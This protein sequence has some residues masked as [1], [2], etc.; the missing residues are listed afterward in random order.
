M[1]Y[2]KTTWVA[3]DVI[4]ATKLNKLEEGAGDIN[5]EYT[6]TVWVAGDVI[7]AVKL[8]KLEQGVADASGGDFVYVAEEQT[9]TFTEGE[10]SIVIDA[11][12]LV[13]HDPVLIKIKEDNLNGTGHFTYIAEDDQTF[14]LLC[15]ST[16]YDPL[17]LEIYTEDGS[18][19]KMMSTNNTMTEPRT[20]T[21]IKMPEF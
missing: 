3:G 13:N 19:W 14:N 4:T 8:N 7:T 5:G 20:V 16:T 11:T 10:G 6:P 18:T 1:S 2:T 21:I 17:G 12:Q 9:I 15:G